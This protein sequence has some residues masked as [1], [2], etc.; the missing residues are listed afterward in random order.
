MREAGFVM[1]ASVRGVVR[2][3][4]R[5]RNATAIAHLVPVTASPFT[6]GLDLLTVS[7]RRGP[8]ATASTGHP[9][10]PGASSTSHIA[11]ECVAQLGGVCFGE[12]D[13]VGRAVEC[14]PDGLDSLAAVD[15]VD[16]GDLNFLGHAV[17]SLTSLRG[18]RQQ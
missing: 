3:E 18:R 13:L 8:P 10:P 9:Y 16:Q 1:R 4:N 11:R 5:R 2:V 12:V 7:P 6:N 15:V 14:K 17:N